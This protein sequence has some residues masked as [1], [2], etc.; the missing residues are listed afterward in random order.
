MAAFNALNPRRGGV[1]GL[2]HRLP[3]VS[4]TASTM[5][6]FQAAASANAEAT[7]VKYESSGLVVTFGNSGNANQ[8]RVVKSVEPARKIP[9]THNA[10]EVP[11]EIDMGNF[12]VGERQKKGTS[13]AGINPVVAAAQVGEGSV[14][15]NSGEMLDEAIQ[16]ASGG[17]STVLDEYW[18]QR[19]LD[20]FQEAAAHTT[21]YVA[22]GNPINFDVA[23]FSEESMDI[24]DDNWKD[25]YA[26]FQISLKTLSDQLSQASDTYD[27]IV[28]VK[29][30][31]LERSFKGI[32]SSCWRSRAQLN[33]FKMQLQGAY[34]DELIQS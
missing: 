29:L 10:P 5:A 4:P 22:P 26:E 20:N 31:A 27:M 13:A 23:K 25:R 21:A 17:R 11:R 33:A 1:G 19:Q 3:R 16:G 12:S 6:A 15:S 34:Y 24:S 9:K 18:Q 2:S 7:S 28:S 32:L 8:Q 30:P 14:A